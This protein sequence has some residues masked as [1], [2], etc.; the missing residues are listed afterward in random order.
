M[1]SPNGHPTMVTMRLGRRD[2]KEG[3]EEERCSAA[4]EGLEGGLW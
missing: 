2:R 4:G 3:A 1:E